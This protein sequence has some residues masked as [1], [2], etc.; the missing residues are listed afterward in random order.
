MKDS[1]AQYLVRCGAVRDWTDEI[2]LGLH[3]PRRRWESTQ[4]WMCRLSQWWCN[5]GTPVWWPV[6]LAVW[7]V[8]FCLTPLDIATDIAFQVQ[9]WWNGV[10]HCTCGC[11]KPC[12]CCRVACTCY[13][14]A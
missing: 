12:G 5:D 1:R 2:R 10:R 7:L 13:A 8:G 14:R 3:A 4:Q 11:R 9:Y 6:V